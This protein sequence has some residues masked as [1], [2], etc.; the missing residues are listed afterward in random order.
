VQAAS[1]PP[2]RDFVLKDY[3]MCSPT[4]GVNIISLTTFLHSELSLPDAVL[5]Y[6]TG[7]PLEEKNQ[8]DTLKLPKAT[9]RYLEKSR[10]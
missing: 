10:S 2:T 3:S 4:P 8:S 5:Y 1:L 9:E 6:T 7:S